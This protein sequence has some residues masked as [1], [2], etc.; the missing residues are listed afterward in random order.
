MTSY[1]SEVF[2]TTSR[3]FE[4]NTFEL[5]IITRKKQPTTSITKCTLKRKKRD[6]IKVEFA[7]WKEQQQVNCETNKQK[8]SLI[9]QLE[10]VLCLC[11]RFQWQ[12]KAKKNES[13]LCVRARERKIICNFLLLMQL[14]FSSSKLLVGE[15]EMHKHFSHSLSL[16]HT[17]HQRFAQPTI[18]IR[19]TDDSGGTGERFL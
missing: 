7:R 18:S 17:H 4:Q 3:K 19:A 9:Y 15:I 1:E 11:S 13:L 8:K 12:S 14:S 2:F 6:L 16:S 10:W 5:K